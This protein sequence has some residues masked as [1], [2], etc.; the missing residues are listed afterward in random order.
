M[1]QAFLFGFTIILVAL[2]IVCA[3]VFGRVFEARSEPINEHQVVPV[4]LETAGTRAYPTEADYNY[5]CVMC[6]K[7]AMDAEEFNDFPCLY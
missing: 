4:Q 6:D 2:G 1:S 5:R 7:H 3:Y